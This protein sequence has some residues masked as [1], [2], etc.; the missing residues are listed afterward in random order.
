MELEGMWGFAT[1]VGP[2][3]LFIL[4]VYVIVRNR[5]SKVPMEVTEEATKANYAAEDRVHKAE[6]RADEE[7]DARKDGPL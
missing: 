2:I 7:E 1:I 4:F 3:A 6:V 5:S